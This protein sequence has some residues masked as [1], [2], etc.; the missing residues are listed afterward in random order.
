M[1]R[2]VLVSS[3]FVTYCR[4]GPGQTEMQVIASLEMQPYVDDGWPNDHAMRQ[5]ISQETRICVVF[6]L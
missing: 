2:A 3:C 6:Y 1:D 5:N 4:R